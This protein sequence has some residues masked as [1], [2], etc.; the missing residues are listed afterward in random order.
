MASLSPVRRYSPT[1]ALAIAAL[2][3][4]A[5]PASAQDQDAFFLAAD[6]SHTGLVTLVFFGPA[7]GSVAFAERVGDRRVG[8]GTVRVGPVSTAAAVLPEATTWR[9]DR[10]TR[11][12]E[13]TETT[14]YGKQLDATFDLRTPS[15]RDRLELR[16]PSRVR[17]GGL[18]TIRVRDRWKLGGVAPQL[19]LAP[20]RKPFACRE[21]VL[22]RAAA[23][24]SRRVRA[25][26][27]GRWRI[28]LRLGAHR[29]RRTVTVGSRALPSPPARAV[30]LTTGDSTIQGI[31]A[32]LADEVGDRA[33]VRSEYFVG[34]GISTNLRPWAQ[35][36][37]KQLATFSPDVTIISIGANE[38]S[39]MNGTE[40]CG[41]AWVAEY[42]RRARAM[43]QTYGRVLW[44]TLPVPRDSRRQIIT[45]AVNAAVIRAAAGFS[46]ARLVRLDE[47]FTPGGIYQEEIRYRGQQVRV[48]QQDGIHLTLP[49][50]SI[51]AGAVA[52]ALP[53]VT[54]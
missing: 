16:A 46:G 23:S 8:L 17:R 6:A 19:C 31:D 13:A 18:L 2:V 54:R 5:T 51:A 30:L 50:L 26:R 4:A 43:M 24:A 9:C 22:R 33:T 28:E 20:P 11:H 45:A 14:P 41:E 49:A 12:F 39:P 15:C 29:T 32:Y 7:D 37:A 3:V 48:R 53:A 36:P 38:G 52:D 47:L 27:P 34:T 21:L 10:L 1:I 44:L 25:D 42:S 35:L 40:C